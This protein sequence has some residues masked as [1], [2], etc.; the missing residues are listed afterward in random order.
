M[1]EEEP[2]KIYMGCVLKLKKT[3]HGVR[4]LYILFCLWAKCYLRPARSKMEIMASMLPLLLLS[5]SFSYMYLFC[6][7]R[8]DKLQCSKNARDY[9]ESNDV[10]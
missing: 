1:L 3:K 6:I 10:F 9:D 2:K 8:G 4:N 7:F 5:L